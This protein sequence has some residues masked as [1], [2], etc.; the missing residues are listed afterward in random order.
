MGT[1]YW[2]PIKIN[3]KNDLK[4]YFPGLDKKKNFKSLE[5]LPKDAQNKIGNLL[6]YAAQI[7]T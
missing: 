3:F 7:D 1:S 2:L 4:K 5:N 6:K